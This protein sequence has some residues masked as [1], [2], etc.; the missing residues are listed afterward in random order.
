MKSSNFPTG[1]DVL[2]F[3]HFTNSMIFKVQNATSHNATFVTLI[4]LK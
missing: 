1:I 3:T 2:M 4:F